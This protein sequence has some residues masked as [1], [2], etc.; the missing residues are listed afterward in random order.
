MSLRDLDIKREYRSLLSNVVDDF[1]TP[2][3]SQAVLYQRAVGFFSSS[4]LMSITEG[5]KGL[6]E[7]G[8]SI[9]LIASPRLSEEDIE[10]IKDG[11][12][13]RDQI[14]SDCLLREL[15]EPKGKFEQSRLNLLSNLIASGILH[16]KIA[17]L[18]TADEIG[19]FHEKVGLVSDS[20][21]NTIAF[22]GSM[23]ESANAFYK[24]Y[25]SIDV[26]TSWGFDA[27]RV[28]DKKVAFTA[29]WGDFEPSLR[30]VE[31]PEVNK[32]IIKR[33]KIKDGVD[34]KDLDVHPIK[35]EM[36]TLKVTDRQNI[37]SIPEGVVIRPY[38]K[39]A[40]EAWKE[41]G[42]RGLFDMATG[43]GKTYTAL[44][45]IT[46]LSESVSHNLAVIIVCPYQHLVE[47]W[48]SD[49]IAFGMHP[50]VCYSA[51]HQKKLETKG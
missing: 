48:K 3:L 23:N 18:E 46:V 4:S 32:A 13:R 44:A 35:P 17:L 14:I 2:V 50:I 28:S 7:N 42:F 15:K 8:G 11:F 31:F 1:Y 37:P 47:Q 26:Y 5:I 6:I 29:M 16:I 34:L 12:E 22:T 51:S 25:E 24:N 30:V 36:E 43:T 41:Q 19:M 39:A 21:G 9:E 38:Q 45:A 33:Y 49:I 27:D 20:E 40:I 10:A